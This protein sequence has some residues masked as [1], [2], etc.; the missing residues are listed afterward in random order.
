[1]RTAEGLSEDQLRWTP[2]DRLLPIIGVINHLS[3]A[4][5]RWID[6]RFL[7]SPFPPREEEFVV[8]TDVTGDQVVA[9]YDARA[10]RTEEIVRAAAHLELPCLGTEG[11]GPPAH[12]LLGLP[13]P[14][15]LRW[16]ILHLIEETAHH[17]GHVDSTREMLDGK[18]ARDLLQLARARIGE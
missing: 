16:T 3:H 9:A 12:V 10:R 17:A 15:D 7:G 13:E 2:G 8:G 18:K 1:M 4:E 5:W 6:G 11:D 14:V